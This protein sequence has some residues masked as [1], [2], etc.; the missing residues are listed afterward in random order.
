MKGKLALIAGAA[1]GYVFGTRAGREQYERLKG[2]AQELWKD[3]RVQDRISEAE[4]RF[5]EKWPE[6]Q[7][8]LTDT[9]KSTAEAARSKL[10]R[11]KEESP[12]GSPT[13]TAGS[14]TSPTSAPSD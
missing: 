12:A 11:E 10:N 3:P 7:A 9:A 14:A 2:R 1:V 6:A 4:H 5:G 8:K 13:A